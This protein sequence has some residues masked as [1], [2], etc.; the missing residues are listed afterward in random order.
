MASSGPTSSGDL[1][2]GVLADVSRRTGSARVL[3]P[4]WRQ[5]VGE[6]LAGAS[7]PLRW[8][9]STLVI[10]CSSAAWATELTRQRTECLRK[11]QLRLGKK[12]VESLVF[13][14]A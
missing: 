5:V 14:A 6:T 13:E 1:L 8:Q 9:G 7:A 4:L 12:M 3:F 11:L 2:A 10:G